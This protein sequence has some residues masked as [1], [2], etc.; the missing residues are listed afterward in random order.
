MR[1]SYDVAVTATDDSRVVSRREQRTS[2]SRNRIL[3]AAVDVLVEL[4]YA[5][6]STMEI[7]KRA[8]VSRGR[9][10]HH[11]GSR[12]AVLVAAAQHLAASRM[13][14]LA[15]DS[16]NGVA[17]PPPESLERIDRAIEVMWDAFQQPYFWAATEL[18]IAS[19][20]NAELGAALRPQEKQL[21]GMVCDLIDGL[22]GP[23]IAASPHYLTVRE[24]LF[25]S[26]RG[27]ALTYAFN[28]R[29]PNTEIHLARWRHVA[30]TVLDPPRPG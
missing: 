2:V 1:C 4:G 25:T 15:D 10:L 22:F 3:N 28:P 11:F 13:A 19:R 24:I 20:H 17:S 9:L 21:Y 26:M 30:H 5:R 18:W 6:A 12:D 16:T 8:D 29:D 14:E 23:V 27:V 7:Q